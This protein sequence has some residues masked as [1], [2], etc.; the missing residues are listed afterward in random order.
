MKLQRGGETA[1]FGLTNS[2]PAKEYSLINGSADGLT[3]FAPLNI[4]ENNT[5]GQCQQFVVA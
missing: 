4:A 2:K 1:F 3:G 5:T